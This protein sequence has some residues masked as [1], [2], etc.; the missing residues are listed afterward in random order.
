MTITTLSTI[1]ERWVLK[2]IEKVITWTRMSFNS[3]KSQ[4]PTLKKGI[5]MERE[6]FNSSGETIQTIQEKPIKRLGKRINRCVKDTIAIQETKDNLEKWLT[7]VD[8]SGLPDRF[9]AHISSSSSSSS[10]RAA[11][12][13]IPD[14]LSPFLSIVHRLWQVFKAT[15]RI[16]T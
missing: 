10:C 12:S 16:L 5:A 1:G 3:S 14:L 6:R 2:G 11:C 9:K 8:K 13:D 15:S 7:E 4:S